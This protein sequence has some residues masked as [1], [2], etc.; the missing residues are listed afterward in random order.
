MADAA[1]FVF[2]AVIV[3]ALFVP[4]VLAG[5]STYRQT[6]SDRR[7]IMAE[8]TIGLATV[9]SLMPGGRSDNCVVRFEFTP[10]GSSQIVSVEQASTM[11]A[12]ADAGIT[13][14]SSVRV[15][16][17]PKW[18]HYAFI[19]ALTLAERMIALTPPSS[20]SVDAGRDRPAVYYVSYS[21]PASSNQ[22]AATNAFRWVGNG[23]VT[24]SAATV[25][26]NA[27]RRRIFLTPKAVT[28][29]FPIAEI[30]NV[31]AFGN[32]VRLEILEPD[33][34][35]KHLTFWTVDAGQATDIAARLPKTR[36]EA[37]TP[38]M[39]EAAE[40]AERLRTLT[41][42][43][44]V[45]TALVGSN[46]VV[47][48]IAALL[49][50]GIITPH[51]EVLIRLGSDYT[52]LTAAGE[53]WR[54]FTSMF[55]HFGILHVGL[56]MW[57]LYTQGKFAERIFG[58]ARF[59]AIYVV[60]GLSGSLVS[61]LWHPIVNGAGASG[62]I[63][64]LLGALLA[65]FLVSRGDVPVSVVQ[66]QRNV[67]LIFVAYSLLNGARFH[68]IDNSAHLGGLVGGFLAGFLFLRPLTADRDERDWGRQWRNAAIAGLCAV[69]AIGWGLQSKALHPRELSDATGHA[70]PLTVLA[71]D[72]VT[73]F[74][75]ITV[76]VSARELLQA[77]GAPV[78]EYSEDH[79]IYNA[80]D[81]KYNALLDVFFAKDPDGHIGNV[82]SVMFSGDES[83]APPELPY[84]SGQ[85]R[86]QLVGIFGNPVREAED[87]SRRHLLF[88]NGVT[89]T[90]VENHVESYGIFF[91]R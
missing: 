30:V 35:A 11:S 22:R 74:S 5:V 42:Q 69:G 64:G 84:L 53:W 65:V 1:L 31:E 83:G 86:Q 76:G 75:G 78:K 66:A 21:D 4:I 67:A 91:L 70:I 19:D 40:F 68:G 82:A 24:I 55:L 73:V 26:F 38:R 60:A 87:G 88:R 51:S 10:A 3:V 41:P 52:P 32:V 15:H 23:D 62:A 54:L 20:S 28:Q 14:G 44:P 16:Y 13:A 25:R 27:G 36:T 17:I 81:P 46:L 18:P 37:F 48:A 79:W 29:D 39:A 63:F 6:R 43:T 72:P 80:S 34:S 85:T 9:R 89:V 7:R 49:G 8:G 12:V 61:F 77:K 59:L 56:N 57:A 50:A 71:G 45:T 58:S 2:I 47:F 33:A 90:I